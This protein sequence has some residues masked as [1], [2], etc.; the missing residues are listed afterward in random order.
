VRIGGTLSTKPLLA[1]LV[2]VMRD[3]K[4]LK[5]GVSE[6][7]TST[8]VLDAVATGKVDIGIMTK[9]V[10]GEDRAQYPAVELATVPI[11]MEVVAV[12]VSNDLWDA[13]VNS[14]TKETMRGIYEQKITNWTDAGG[15][16]EKVRFFNIE[17]GQG[18]WEIFAEWVY[19]DNRKAPLPKVEKVATSEDA[20]DSLEF[21]P[22]A[23]APLAAPLA[24][25]SR[26][27]ALAIDLGERVAKPTVEGVAAGNYPLERPIVAL[28]VG[29]PTLSIRVVT[30][31]L[32][33]PEGQALVKKGGDM[34]LEAAPKPRKNPYY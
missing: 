24:D 16:D 25:G 9:L 26:C 4:G 13:G 6:C 1:D 32:T 2:R 30:E 11:G 17:Q 12:G 10:T 3:S 15:P 5:I 33:G 21:T 19:G 29:K 22:G 14:I 7:V 31:F 27:H 18:V 28:V 23:I 8:D 34:G 20:R